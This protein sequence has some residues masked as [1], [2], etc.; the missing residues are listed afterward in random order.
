MVEE[1]VIYYFVSECYFFAVDLPSEIVNLKNSANIRDIRD[2][3]VWA[4]SEKLKTNMYN[5]SLEQSLSGSEKRNS[6]LES[7]TNSIGSSYDYTLFPAYYSPRLF[8]GSASASPTYRYSPP[9]TNSAKIPPFSPFYAS[10]NKIGEFYGCSSASESQRTT[11]VIM[12]VEQQKVVEWKPKDFNARSSS[13]SEDENIVC[14]W[15]YC[16]R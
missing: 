5:S 2:L 15:K 6:L 11:S 8:E 13:E 7:L 4:P 1:T 16:Y 10:L 14:K 9:Q 12:K 3:V